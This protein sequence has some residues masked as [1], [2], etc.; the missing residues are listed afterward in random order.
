MLRRWETKLRYYE[1]RVY[2]DLFGTVILQTCNG[3]R[4]VRLGMSRVVAFGEE[5][6]ALA[7]KH[8]ER[9]RIKH[10]YAEVS[11]VCLGNPA[12]AAA[13]AQAGSE[14]GG[15]VLGDARRTGRKQGRRIHVGA[16]I[17]RER[18][19]SPS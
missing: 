19:A 16:R 15:L 9:T 4:G 3:G 17:R 18:A 8:I 5:E 12:A 10:G 11:M 6:V 13:A 7:L 2:R 14:R 1:A